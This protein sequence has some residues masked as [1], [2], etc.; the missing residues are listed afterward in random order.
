MSSLGLAFCCAK[1]KFHYTEREYAVCALT[2][3]LRTD[4]S[5]PGHRLQFEWI[6]WKRGRARAAGFLAEEP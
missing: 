3:A 2:F 4:R 1:G 5:Q 6:Q